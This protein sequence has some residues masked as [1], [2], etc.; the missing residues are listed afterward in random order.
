MQPLISHLTSLFLL[1]WVELFP[2]IALP[3]VVEWIRP[4]CSFVCVLLI[5]LCVFG[6]FVRLG[7]LTDPRRSG[8]PSL[9]G[10]R[11]GHATASTH[12]CFHSAGLHGCRGR[13]YRSL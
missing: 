9:P 3:F 4:F 12:R 10:A 7:H 8:L 2:S 6:G 5:S 1:I 11:H 13:F